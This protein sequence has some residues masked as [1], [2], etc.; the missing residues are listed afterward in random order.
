[1]PNSNSAGKAEKMCK[2]N[3]SE[4]EITPEMIEAGASILYGMELAFAREEYWAEEVYR[5]MDA[6]RREMKN[7]PHRHNP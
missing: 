6:K 7:D 1:M 5:A 3:E 2:P 4:I